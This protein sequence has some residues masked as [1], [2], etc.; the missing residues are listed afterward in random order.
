MEVNVI[1]E[2]LSDNA[3]KFGKMYSAIEKKADNGGDREADWLDSIDSEMMKHLKGLTDNP[4]KDFDDIKDEKVKKQLF[5][6]V[7][8]LSGI[9]L[10]SYK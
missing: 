2:Q 6:R 10:G 3:K 7:S 9:D 8:Q 5:D 1:N 4:A